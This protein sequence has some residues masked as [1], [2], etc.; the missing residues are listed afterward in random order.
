MCCR[1]KEFSMEISHVSY[2]IHPTNDRKKPYGSIFTNQYQ[3]SVQQKVAFLVVLSNIIW[4]KNFLFSDFLFS[5][6]TK[7]K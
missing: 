1:E 2:I 3:I 5:L 7:I 6:I 4:I